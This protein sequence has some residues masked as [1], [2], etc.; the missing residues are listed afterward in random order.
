MNDDLSANGTEV[1]QLDHQ[2]RRPA[3]SS[4]NP[5]INVAFPFGRIA[6]QEPSEVLCDLAGLVEQL[7]EQVVSLTRQADP[8][9][10]EAA[11]RLAA[12][13]AALAHRLGV[14]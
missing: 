13:A 5:R 12:Q 2:R 7:A 6:V 4:G 9:Q 3:V 14:G 1:G 10:A 11:D 8:G